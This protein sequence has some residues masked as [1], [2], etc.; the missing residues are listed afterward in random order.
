MTLSVEYVSPGVH[1]WG[2]ASSITTDG[3][4]TVSVAPLHRSRLANVWSRLM[5]RSKT[6]IVVGCAALIFGAM[7]S[8]AAWS[9]GE[10]TGALIVGLPFMAAG[11][12]LAYMLKLTAGDDELKV[13]VDG[14][15]S[16]ASLRIVTTRALAEPWSDSLHD[17]VFR[18]AVQVK[19]GGTAHSLRKPVSTGGED[20]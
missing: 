17:Q 4:Q 3:S 18:A 10:L 2:W 19:R 5:Y 20:N 6:S 7:V 15:Q 8:I 13:R 9:M 1:K 12:A 14:S 11:V 16:C